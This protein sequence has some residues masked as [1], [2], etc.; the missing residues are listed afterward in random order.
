MTLLYTKASPSRRL[1]ILQHLRGY[2]AAAAIVQRPEDGLLLRQQD[3]RVVKF[4][5]RPVVQDGHPIIVGDGIKLVCHRQDGVV[6]EFLSDDPLNLGIG[7]IVDAAGGVSTN[8]KSRN[9]RCLPAGR[10]V[11]HKDRALP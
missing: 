6:A 10:L 4:L 3:M 1:S 9:K 11:K 8:C 5:H 7:L 2:S